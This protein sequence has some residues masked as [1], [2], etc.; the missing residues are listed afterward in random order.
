MSST[1]AEEWHRFLQVT[2]YIPA[3]YRLYR[4]SAPNYVNE[5]SDQKLTDTAVA[6]LVDKKITRIISANAVKYNA[7][8]LGRLQKAGISYLHLP[9]VDFTAPTIA[10]LTSAADFFRAATNTGTLVHCGYGY[11]RTGT[12]VTGLQLSMTSG[13]NPPESDWM[14]VNHV[15]KPGQVDVLNEW[16][17]KIQFQ[18]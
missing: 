3:P 12:F 10:Q 7:T 13:K 1:Q 4:S 14:S 9:V 6:F 11:G 16:I 2:N 15:E 18:L 5:D 8:E 17:K